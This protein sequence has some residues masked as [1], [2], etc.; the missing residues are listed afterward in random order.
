MCEIKL[1]LA[2]LSPTD[3]NEGMKTLRLWET[4]TFLKWAGKLEAQT[5]K[6]IYRR[7]RIACA[8]GH[9]GDHHGV[10]G[11]DDISEMRFDFAHGYRV[12]YTVMQ[13]EL[14]LLALVGGNKSTQAADIQRARR[15]LPIALAQV[16]KELEEEKQREQAGQ[17]GRT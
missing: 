4:E 16:R 13:N 12:Y 14:V 11:A 3:D 6:R 7:I 1:F 9:F 17:T 8:T 2:F 5:Y 10:K 15:M